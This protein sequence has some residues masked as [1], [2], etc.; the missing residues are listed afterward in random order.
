MEKTTHER[1]R[2]GDH[3]GHAALIIAAVV[4]TLNVVVG[5]TFGFLLLRVVQK[6][7]QRERQDIRDARQ[8]SFRICDRGN[9]TR[10]ELHVAY[11]SPP[12][13]KAKI[14]AIAKTEP[15]LAALLA[16]SQRAQATGLRRVRTLNP[17]LGCEPNLE[18]KAATVKSPEAQRRFVEDYR[19][20]TLPPLPVPRPPR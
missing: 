4:L 3:F 9:Y 1:R 19:S 15:E 12:V 8:A 6:Q 7:D 13:P 2:V 14:A 20:V 16:A 5:G 17:I 11:A 10:A 18:G